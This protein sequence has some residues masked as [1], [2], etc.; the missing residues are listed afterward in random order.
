VLNH[1]DPDG[2]TVTLAENLFEGIPVSVTLVNRK[3]YVGYVWDLP[4]SPR[5]KYFSLMLLLSGYRDEDTLAFR[6]SINYADKTELD[7][8]MP[9]YFI[10][11]IAIKDVVTANPFDPE[12][13]RL[14]FDRRLTER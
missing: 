2:L 6:E 11:T 4:K 12:E 1:E 14:T 3:V 9:K 8:Q 5:D 7:Q 10:I 13:Y